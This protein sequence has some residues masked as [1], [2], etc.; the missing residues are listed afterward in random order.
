[1]T[2]LLASDISITAWTLAI[3]AAFIIG[4]SKA[5]IKGIAIVNVT[6]C[7]Y[8]CSYLLQSSY[9]MEVHFT[10][11]TLDDGRSSY[12]GIYRARS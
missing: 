10:I 8:F 4:L 3:T 11:F 5:G 6:S 2:L 7:G 9:A 12:W 1:V